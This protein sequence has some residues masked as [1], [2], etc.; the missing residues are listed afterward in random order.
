MIISYVVVKWQIM[1]NTADHRLPMI[2]NPSRRRIMQLE[3]IHHAPTGEAKPTPILFV[4]G[5]WHA[6]WCWNEYFLPYF[7]GCGYDVHALSLRG[8]G[9]SEG[10]NRLRWISN[11]EYVEDVAQ[12]ASGLSTPPIIIGHSMG[13]FVVQKYLETYP[14]PAAVLLAS[15]PP[16]GALP[17]VLRSLLHHPIS[18]LTAT[19]TLTLYHMV[20]TPKKARD[21]FFSPDMPQA[22]VDAYFA[23]IQNESFRML[24]DTV[25]LALPRPA[26]VRQKD[27][28]MLVLGAEKDKIFTPSEVKATAHSYDADAEFFPNMAHDMM[29]EAG[30]QAVADRIIGW[31]DEEKL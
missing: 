2:Q 11:G 15:I 9:E 6:A 10:R 26:K 13:G 20:N 1:S 28:P 25:L 18:T 12:V 7:A 19:F 31:L 16:I 23:R 4:H 27:I 22:Q 14:A 29:L 5:A 21:A 8:H 17:F 3:V 30:W 24:L